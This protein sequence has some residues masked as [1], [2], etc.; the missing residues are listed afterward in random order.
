VSGYLLMGEIFIGE[1]MSDNTIKFTD[2]TF[3]DGRQSSLAACLRIE[4]MA[5]IAAEM[6]RA[7]FHLHP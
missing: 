3:R 5:P 2:V 6:D 1:L 4:D 7:G